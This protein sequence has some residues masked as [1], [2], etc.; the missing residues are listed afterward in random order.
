[1]SNNTN[2]YLYRWLHF[3]NLLDLSTRIVSSTTPPVTERATVEK[4]TTNRP[5][6]TSQ[7]ETSSRSTVMSSD[8]PTS[9]YLS[10]VKTDLS[11]ERQP[12]EQLTTTVKTVFSSESSKKEE[13]TAAG[14]NGTLYIKTIFLQYFI[15]NSHCCN[16]V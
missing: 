8:T 10:T 16:G 14:P 3:L 9:E 1:M 11:S 5:L 12:S 15:T 7:H 2:I 4:T 13:E 6:P